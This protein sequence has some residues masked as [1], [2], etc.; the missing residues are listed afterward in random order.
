[1]EMES[2][3][4]EDIIARMKNAYAKDDRTTLYDHLNSAGK[5]AEQMLSRLY[6]S[7]EALSKYGL[8]S[9]LLKQ[10]IS[11]ATYAHDL[12]KLDPDFQRHLFEQTACIPHAFLSLYPANIALQRL[13]VSNGKQRDIL[14][15]IALLSIAT[16]HSDYHDGLYG[17]YRSS[18]STD[19]LFNTEESARIL[20]TSFRILDRLDRYGRYLYALANGVLRTSD[21]AVSAKLRQKEVFIEDVESIKSAVKKYI[22]AKGVIRDYQNLASNNENKAS[23]LRLPTGDGKTETALLA[24]PVNANKVIYTLPTVTTVESMR[25]RFHEYFGKDMVSF[26]HH[27]LLLSLYEEEGM[28][29]TRELKEQFRYLMRPIVATTID[30]I[31]LSVMN[32]RHYS[33]VEIALNNAYL[34]VDEI[35][36]YP[37]YTLSLIVNGLEYFSKFHGTKILVMSA[38][39]PELIREK[40]TER[41]DL[42]PLIPDELSNKRYT[43]RNRVAIREE[44][45]DLMNDLEDIVRFCKEKKNVLI[46]VNTVNRAVKVYEKLKEKIDDQSIN[47]FLIHGRFSLEDKRRKIDELNS[48]MDSGADLPTIL[49]STQLVEVSL[50]IDFDVL[51]TEIAPL[52]ALLQRFGRVNRYGLRQKA[53]VRVYPVESCKPYQEGQIK[54]TEENMIYDPSSELDFLSATDKYYERLRTEYER[55]LSKHPLDDF[56]NS[57]SVSSF[58][59]KTMRTRDGFVTVPV[60]PVGSDLS[61]YN[62]LKENYDMNKDKFEFIINI[63]K[64]IVEAPVSI[65]KDLI[66]EDQDFL[67]G[68]F[69]IKADYSQEIGLISKPGGD[70]L[71]Y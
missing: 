37:P 43:G 9:S 65:V 31:L 14:N 44:K 20:K 12:G 66:I 35:H 23:Y 71:I 64:K 22:E 3:F 5:F 8:D 13:V 4:S 34:V 28:E 54:A 69:L 25:K 40:F 52:D 15:A 27:L 26:T 48:I 56:I 63:S 7:D 19:S 62:K 49:I 24:L 70:A 51:F 10:I 32:S 38:T 36:S 39:L 41:L 33:M 67:N 46:V 18:R 60:I 6:I 21:W 1:M 68:V 58:G 30:R 47:L 59:E 42:Q 45:T 16:H 29:R 61:L 11:F 17:R 53:E 55:E 57:I 50:N 2:I